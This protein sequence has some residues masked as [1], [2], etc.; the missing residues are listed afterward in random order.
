VG[1][2]PILFGPCIRISCTGHPSYL[3]SPIF[4]L[5]QEEIEVAALIGLQ[6]GILK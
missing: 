3:L 5:A 4:A 6:Y 2:R 1:L